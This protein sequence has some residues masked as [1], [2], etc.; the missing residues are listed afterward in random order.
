VGYTLGAHKGTE[1]IYDALDAM[2]VYQTRPR[3]DKL[4][5]VDHLLASLVHLFV[6]TE[7]RDEPQRKP[8]LVDRV[9]AAVEK[10]EGRAVTV[11][12]IAREFG[13]S[14]TYVRAQFRSAEGLSL[15]EYID[16]ERANVA[17]QYLSYSDMSIK[18]IAALMELPDPQ[19][20]SRF[21]RRLT[22]RSP[23]EIRRSLEGGTNVKA[24]ERP[25]R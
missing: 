18:E 23:R 21:C 22:E 17:V 15:K 6:Q 11:A 2:L 5:A 12:A 14:E 1:A 3:S 13:F 7:E 24:G 4:A 20:F 25:L 19:C 8:T 16:R 10:R 9:K